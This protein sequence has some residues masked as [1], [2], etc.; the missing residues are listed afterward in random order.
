VL[1]ALAAGQVDGAFVGTEQAFYYKNKGQAFFRIALTGYDPHAEALAFKSPELAEAIAKVM[2][3]MKA[4][5]SF[6]KLFS[7]Y[8]HCTLP[9][10]YKVETGPLPPPKCEVAAAD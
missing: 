3:E 2:N 4:D 9:G 10:P 7:S 5:G 8:H 1:Q 6:D